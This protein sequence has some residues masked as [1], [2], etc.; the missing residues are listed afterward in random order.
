M[1]DLIQKWKDLPFEDRKNF[2]DNISAFMQIQYE[3]QKEK[4]RQDIE[5]T[6]QEKEKTRQDMEKTQKE[7]F[8]AETANKLSELR[9][10]VEMKETER[11]RLGWL[12]CK[13][14]CKIR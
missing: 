14:I 9:R 3:I 7:K 8:S 13:K 11:N 6:Q 5:K 12:V 1:T 2:G 10:S 4:T